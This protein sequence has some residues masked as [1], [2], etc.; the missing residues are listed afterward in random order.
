MN[1][2]DKSNPESV[3]KELSTAFQGLLSWSWDDYFGTVLAQFDL[4]STDKIHAILTRYLSS[5]LDS[6][7]ISNA[8]ESVQ[9]VSRSLGNLMAGQ[10]LY[11]SAAESNAFVF[12]AW[13]PWGNGTTISIR[14]AAYNKDEYETEKNENIKNLKDWFG[15]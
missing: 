2:L 9:A 3:C 11:I 12:C 4:D 1:D 6:T 15:V 8:S 7:S 10:L 14:I 13:W 5:T